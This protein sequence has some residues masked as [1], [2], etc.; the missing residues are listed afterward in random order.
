MPARLWLAAVTVFWLAMSAWLWRAEFGERRQPGNVPAQ[1]VWQ[2]ILT[3]P[4]FSNLEIRH[5]TNAIGFCHW[6]PDLGQESATGAR[7]MEEDEPLEGM[8]P[9]LAY[10]SLDFDGSL[11]LPDFPT[12]VRFSMG[13]RL[14]TNRVWQQFDARVAMPPDV[15]ELS[16]NA[17]AQTVRL[18]VDA[19]GDKMNRTFRFAELQN[20]QRVLQEL[21]GP[22]L[23]AIVGAMGVPLTTNTLSPT[24]LGWRWDARN[25]S[26]LVGGNRVRAYRLQTKLFD[27]YRI[28]FFVSSVG[29]ILRAEFPGDIVLVNEALAGFHGTIP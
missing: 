20:P 10:Y 14:D 5:K 25:D 29:E 1:V 4:D 24:S 17:A 12:R 6:R 21:G 28:A 11:T 7:L 23:P 9:R 15:Y 27:R 19:G 13:L 18:R 26:I 16:A 22:M 2:K 8:V 3:A